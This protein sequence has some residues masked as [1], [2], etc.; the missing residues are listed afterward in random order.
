MAIAWG[1]SP[2]IEKYIPLGDFPADKY[3]I[4]AKQ[5]AENLGWKISHVSDIGVIAYTPLSWQ[6]YSEEVAIKIV[7]NFAVVKSECI[8]IQLLFNDYGKSDSNLDQF[9]HEFKYVEF[10]LKD[11]WDE[12]L[13]SFHA[14]ANQ[15]DKD[16]FEKA[17]LTAKNKIKN[18]LYLF[19][20][21]KNYQIT[22]I[23]ILINIALYFLKII[24][25]I[26]YFSYVFKH[27]LA[28]NEIENLYYYLGG[29]NRE[30][31]LNGQYWRL[32]TYQFIHGSF[33]H[34]FFNMYALAYIGLMVEHKLS[35]KKYLTIYIL[36]GI[37]G[38][39]L[40]MFYHTDG[41]MVGAS[42][43]I[44]GMFGAFLALLVG[45]AFEKNATKAMLI[46]TISVTLIMLLNGLRG[47]IDNA[48]HIGG[49]VFGFLITV[50]LFHHNPLNIKFQ[51]KQRYFIAVLL[52][53]SFAIPSLVF[54]PHYQIKE[55]NLLELEYQ[56]NARK[57]TT[58]Y[59]L[60][61]DLSK[62]EKL[63]AIKINGIK[64]W[65]ANDSIVKKM[66]VLTVEKR[67]KQI[68]SFHQK[69]VKRHLELVNLFY[70]KTNNDGPTYLY[71]TD[72]QSLQMEI[73]NIRLNIKNSTRF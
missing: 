35:A 58:I 69:M 34:L 47:G 49:L 54:M 60:K 16:Y 37:C 68:I 14:F 18:V 21:Q 13:A 52:A 1:Y 33:S 62:E 38:G 20:P 2:K 42:G 15:Q 53:I 24:A 29:N 61:R 46:S 31:V 43:A 70:K 59:L 7:N 11:V 6:S 45:K 55:F 64:V 50:F 23:L 71:D 41:F 4:I 27:K 67:Q 25:S 44:M 22:P 30:V 39:V 32:L 73:N 65:K 56:L 10:H 5:A 3:I 48:A 26:V 9:F 19:L 36:S 72:I 28:I 66:E 57:F 51:E 8:G 63:N 12:T 17:P 40:S